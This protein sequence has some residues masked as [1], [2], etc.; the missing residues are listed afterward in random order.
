[1]KYVITLFF[2]FISLSSLYSCS[3]N[4]KH[5]NDFT[6]IQ[7][8]GELIS[9]KRFDQD[10]Y[11]YLQV[12]SFQQQDSLA[13]SYGKFL[14]A[15]G[16]VTINNNDVSG[17]SYFSDLKGYFSNPMLSQIYKDALD[18]FRVVL[19]YEKELSVADELIQKYFAGK[20]LPRLGMHVSGFKANTIV[21]A[22]FISISIDRYLGADYSGYKDFFEDY[23]RQ[24][25]KPQMI[26]RDYL[27]AWIL[28][29]MP[30]SNKRKDLL[31]EIINEG[32]TLYALQLL[33]PDWNEADLI[34]YTPEQLEW[35]KNKEKEIWKATID[36]NYLF[37]TDYMTI[38]KYLEDAPYTA[39]IST[40]SPGRL[41]A[42]IGWQIVKAYAANTSA[43][44]DSIIKESDMQNILKQSKYN[45]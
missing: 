37:S 35:S 32:K 6:S 34:G 12:P 45:P 4:S 20:Q 24:Q 11:R 18:T 14:E 23:Q 13:K 42:W 36:Q 5:R 15:F 17:T 9:I 10:L 39:T 19:P 29:E 21:L 22:D 43:S 31:S 33:L 16:T 44:L 8:Q 27:K 26:S 3:N 41:G 1:M 38:L 2:L 7:N 28:T 25:M 40:D 30:T